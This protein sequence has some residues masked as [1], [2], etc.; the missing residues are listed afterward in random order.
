MLNIRGGSPEHRLSKDTNSPRTEE[1]L[2]DETD[3]SSDKSGEERERRERRREKRDRKM[4]QRDR[5]RERRLLEA[6]RDNK[7]KM[8]EQQPKDS[9]Q[10]CVYYLQG[11][12]QKVKGRCGCRL[13]AAILISNL[14]NFRVMTVST[15]T[16]RNPR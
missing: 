2:S 14:E 8:M 7:N 3:Y 1:T 15:R 16:N 4:R 10:L 6:N 9:A 13:N 5:G 11:K 12:C